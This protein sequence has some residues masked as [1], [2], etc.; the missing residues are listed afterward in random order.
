M[1]G[2]DSHSFTKSVGAIGMEINILSKTVII[3]ELRIENFL[4]LETRYCSN[5]L[6]GGA[7]RMAVQSSLIVLN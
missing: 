1:Q 4:W 2:D 3:E 5:F 7:N 6:Y